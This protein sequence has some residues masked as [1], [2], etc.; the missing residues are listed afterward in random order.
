LAANPAC[1]E[2][3]Q[4]RQRSAQRELRQLE[5]ADVARELLPE[6]ERRRVLQVGAPDLDD[7]GERIALQREGIAEGLHRRDDVL[8]DGPRGGDVH[9]GR[10]HVVRRLPEVHVVIRVHQTLLAALA[11]EQLR[12]AV[13]KHLVDV[14]VAL[15]ARA[16]LPDGQRKLLFVLSG[17]HF[18]RGARYRLRLARLEQAELGVRQRRALLDQ[19]EGVDYLRRHALGRDAEEAPA[20]LGLRAPKPPGGHLDRPEAV[21]LDA[22]AAHRGGYVTSSAGCAASRRSSRAPACAA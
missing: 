15:R 10:K 18:R 3:V 17:E 11:A 7:S 4:R 2:L 5:L 19:R 6:R 20:A 16:G 12:G 8:V 22:A 14:H 1:G 21:L 13:G 9:R